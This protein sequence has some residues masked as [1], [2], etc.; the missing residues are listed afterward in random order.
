MRATAFIIFFSLF[1]AV[2]GLVNY[3]I[4]IRG[5]QAIP[6]GSPWRRPYLVLFLILASSYFAGRLLERVWLS[7]ASDALV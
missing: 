6:F 4:F 3:Y 1:F 2:Y 7:W 5:W